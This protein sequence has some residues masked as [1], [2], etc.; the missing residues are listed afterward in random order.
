MLGGMVGAILTFMII[1]PYISGIGLLVFL[2]IF[3]VVGGFVGKKLNQYIR[4]WGTAIIGAGLI[5]LGMNSFFGGMPGTN[6][7]SLDLTTE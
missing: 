5:C 1:A 6:S 3:V 7:N 4:V 2:V